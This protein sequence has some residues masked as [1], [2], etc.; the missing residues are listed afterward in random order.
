MA[1][2]LTGRRSP[3]GLA[4]GVVVI[5]ALVLVAFAGTGSANQNHAAK[6]QKALA[7]GTVYFAEPASAVPNYIFPFMS[8]AFFSVNNISDLQQIMYRPLYWFGQGT[9]PGLNLTRSLA[10]NPKYSKNNTVVSFTLKPYK[11]SNGESVTAQ[12]VVFWMNML[13]VEKLGWAAYVPGGMPDDVK[14]VVANSPT[15]VTI[16]LTGPVNP[17]WFTYNE[18]SQI[19]PFPMAWSISAKGAKAGSEACGNA[20]YASV[21]TKTDKKNTKVTPVSAAAKSCDKVYAFLSRESGFDPKNPKAPNNSL[22]TYAT[23]PIWQVVNGPFRLSKFD[24]AGNVEMV[25]NPKYSGPVKPK[26]DK[27][28]QLPFTST[29][30]EFNALVGGKVDVGYIPQEDLTS[31]AKSPLEPGKNHPRLKDFDLEAWYSWGITYFPYNFNSTGNGG[32][33][34]KIFR[35]LYFRQAFQSLVNQPLYIEK[36]YHNYAPPTY[37]PVPV[38]PKNPFATKFASQNP[39]PYSVDKAKS[40]LTENGWKVDPKGVTSCVDAAKCGVPA[41]TKLQ[42]TLQYA[43]GSAT[44]KQ[45]MEAQQAAWQQAGIKI[46]LTTASFNTVI[47]NAIPCSGKSC[48]WELASWGGWVYAPDYYPSGELLFQTG[49]GS[50]SGS[51]SDKKNDALIHDTAFGDATLAQWQNY[52]AKQLPVVWQPNTAYQI[53]EVRKNL[54]GVFP[55]NPLLTINPEDWF[56]TK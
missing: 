22:K 28:V 9:G 36:L 32:T 51:Y 42:F 38:I 3:L 1:S 13:K 39:Y 10:S 19:T 27:F 37:G 46:T 20:S 29:A 41:G 50:N 14:S 55:Q 34:G 45:L 26:I 12:Q 54:K 47:G 8:L 43:S 6:P 11:W 52:L 23:N 33:A 21:T 35:Q 48:S 30:A 56:F 49:A 24:S 18:L 4:A 31:S 40:L 44:T 17:Y 25:P 53:T 7:G 5:A 16:T 15:K 2:L